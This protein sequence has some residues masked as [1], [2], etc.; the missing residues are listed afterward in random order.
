MISDVDSYLGIN[1]DSEIEK[2]EL[3]NLP[4]SEDPLDLSQNEIGKSQ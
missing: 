4:A 1:M 2:V 3:L